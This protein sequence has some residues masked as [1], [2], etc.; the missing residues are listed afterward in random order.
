[1][2]LMI[3][4]RMILRVL[5]ANINRARE[6]LRVC[7]DVVRFCLGLRGPFQQLRALRRALDAQVR[8]LP[9]KP[10]DV[11][12]FRNSQQDPGRFAHSP[13]VKS[14]EHLL[15][16]NLQRTKE[17]LRVLEE[18]SRLVA[19]RQV[20]SF[21]RLRFGTYHVERGLLIGVA[22]LRHRR[23]IRRQGS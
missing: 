15:L 9:V 4:R 20:A 2:S 13:A 14:I 16:I 21:Q 12:R 6:G 1:M 11:V 5:D 10:V 3:P 19:P 17:A 7:E 18:S 22:A 23:Q 8:R